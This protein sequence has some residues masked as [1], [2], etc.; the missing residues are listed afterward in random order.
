MHREA[1]V[2]EQHK[3]TLVAA[4]RA[5]PPPR[6]QPAPA[7]RNIA[8][9]S[10][11]NNESDLKIWETISKHIPISEIYGVGGED[12]L[13]GCSDKFVRD[14]IRSRRASTCSGRREL[15]CCGET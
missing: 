2:T 9:T 10:A 4:V 1:G 3:S 12:L 11:K 7:A 8:P 13:V 6:R 14:I 15:G 5:P